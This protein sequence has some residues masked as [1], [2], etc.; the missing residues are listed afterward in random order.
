MVG[1]ETKAKLM[2]HQDAVRRATEALRAKTAQQIYI[3]G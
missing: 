1:P 3:I 2:I